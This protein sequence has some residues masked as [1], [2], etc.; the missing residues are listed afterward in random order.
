MH[1]AVNDSERTGI[2][3]HPVQDAV[4]FAAAGS[5]VDVFRQSASLHPERI[6]LSDE[7]T[8][9]TY[10]ELA[11][12]GDTLAH[13]LL[14]AGLGNGERVG[15]LVDRTVGFG[16]AVL[17]IL[18]AGAA[19]V[20]V[21]P[22]LPNARIAEVLA[23]ARV[24]T[25]VVDHLSDSPGLAGI[26]QIVLPT[27]PATKAP[28]PVPA[29]AAPTPSSTAYVIYTSG[30]TGRPKGVLVSHYSVVEMLRHTLPLYQL[31]ESD[32]WTRFHSGSFDFS[33][34]ELWGAWASGARCHIVS[35]QT[36]RSPSALLELLRHE[37]V[38]VLNQVPTVFTHLV[39]AYE[40][41]GAPALGLRYV[42]FGGE[43]VNLSVVA[44]Y[45]T[46]SS[47][48]APIF[49]N[50]YGITETTV[51]ATSRVLDDSLDSAVR[52]PIG[53]ALPHL[54]IAVLDEDRR[55]VE[56]GGTG[57]LWIS[58]SSVADG[59][60]GKPELT[61]ERFVVLD[62]G[63]G[64]ARHYRSG[65]VARVL[66]DGELEYVGRNDDQVKLRGFRIELGE[67]ESVL[68]QHPAVANAVA[69]VVTGPGELSSLVALL[70]RRPGL[71]P[72]DIVEDVR[73]RVSTRLPAHFHPNRYVV[74]AELPQTTSGKL[75]RAAATRLAAVPDSGGAAASAPSD[76]TTAAICLRAA[77]LLGLAGLSPDQDL[78]ELGLDSLGTTRLMRRLYLHDGLRLDAQAFR[79][80][81]TPRSIS[82][83]HT[84]LRSPASIVSVDPSAAPLVAQ[85]QV[86]LWLDDQM[87][88]ERRAANIIPL[89][90][91]I[92]GVGDHGA[93]RVAQALSRV[94]QR[95]DAL[96]TAV[97]DDPDG[98]P[99]G[100]ALATAEA[101]TARV[102]PEPVPPLARD[103]IQDRLDKLF[104]FVDLERGPLVV[105]EIVKESGGT[106]LLAL[107]VHHAAFDGHSQSLLVAELRALLAGLELPDPAPYQLYVRSTSSS[108][109]PTATAK[110]EAKL[111]GT[112]DIEWPSGGQLTQ[113]EQGPSYA[114]LD[115]SIP[116]PLL[117]ELSAT[118]AR[119]RL[120]PFVL[121]LRAFGA[122]VRE[123]TGTPSFRVG[124]PISSRN[125]SQWHDTVGYFVRMAIVPFDRETFAD[126]VIG[127]A[128]AWQEA[129]RHTGLPLTEF[130]RALGTH[131]GG[132][133]T[134]FQA[135][136]AWQSHLT[137]DATTSGPALHALPVMPLAPQY[138]LTAEIWPPATP[139]T[140]AVARFGYDEEIVAPTTARHLR[141]AFISI[142][143]Q[144]NTL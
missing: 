11:R 33:V 98:I 73:S 125:F 119:H 40:E 31:T 126:P 22:S 21:D 35:L 32:V 114:E 82:L 84:R 137:P 117:E 79:E 136:F 113:D 91:R 131:T 44:R 87:R 39:E 67:I 23:D 27:D 28:V 101:L 29:T 133:T 138:D 38:T 109:Q 118:A 122:A 53:R 89:A 116:G 26:H 141:D 15:L 46:L 85:E 64:P 30:S 106:V 4:L 144:H 83:E 65:D 86:S 51:H 34:W 52:S 3:S 102:C 120:T 72:V 97:R 105:A 121:A 80:N 42:M 88:P 95:H 103:D 96:R 69:V 47:A 62:T 71:Y 142:L 140:P 14:A 10:A 81:A 63:C 107:A 134:L 7:S 112:G 16:V 74:V 6:G 41:D 123:V 127:V 12:L 132:H 104:Q 54:R 48:P 36:A 108:P 8:E 94:V 1:D 55:P 49:V 18:R 92:D 56:V 135:Q 25:V 99:T 19:Y 9:L 43:S 24:R 124:V 143:W 57:E 77:E 2:V 37:G 17:G 129:L 58:G 90:Y 45:R 20:P 61:A 110:W 139:S 130:A 13:S 68:R 76:T 78:R 111:R 59:Y 66:P 128:E 50:L 60:L 115:W 5:L 70:V 93:Q 75:D 100:Y